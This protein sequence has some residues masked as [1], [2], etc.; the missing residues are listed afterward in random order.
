MVQGG[1]RD[2]KYFQKCSSAGLEGILKAQ[3]SADR[4]EAMAPVTSSVWW[5]CPPVILENRHKTPGLQ[6]SSFSFVATQHHVVAQ[7]GLELIVFSLGFPGPGMTS[8]CHRT[9]LGVS[10]ESTA[11]PQILKT[12]YHFLFFALRREPR[13]HLT[14]WYV[15]LKPTNN[16]E[17]K[18]SP[19]GHEC[20]HSSALRGAPLPESVREM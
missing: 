1:S 17:E 3:C 7:A 14:S 6:I 5:L 4:S 13:P 16:L 9:H 15:D 10:F 8:V 11:S 20:S 19:R 2:R 18:V 12:S